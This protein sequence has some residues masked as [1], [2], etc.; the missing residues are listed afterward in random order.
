MNVFGQSAELAILLKLKDEVT[1]PLNN[2]DRSL[3][4]LNTRT[5]TVSGGLTK[6]GGG[7]ALG[8][9]RLAIGLVAV[10]GSVAAVAVSA[11][12]AAAQYQ[13]A[14]ELVHTQAGATQAEVETISAALLEARAAGRFQR[15]RSRRRA[16]PHRVG[17][18]PGS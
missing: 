17:R 13:S 7:L 11:T 18:R 12:N 5:A 15:Y 6:I 1:G 8:A 3:S 4:G 14:M 10:G 16:L 2:I 9:E